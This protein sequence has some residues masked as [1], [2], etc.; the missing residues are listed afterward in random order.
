MVTGSGR[1]SGGSKVGPR[2][3]QSTVCEGVEYLFAFPHM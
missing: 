3:R 1:S 2:G